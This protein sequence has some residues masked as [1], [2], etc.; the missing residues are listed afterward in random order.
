MTGKLD[1]LYA[2]QAHKAFLLL[3]PKKVKSACF[4]L[5]LSQYFQC[6]PEY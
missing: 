1:A 3:P 2:I 4:D 6:L 5:F